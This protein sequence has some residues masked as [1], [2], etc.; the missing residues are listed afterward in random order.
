MRKKVARVVKMNVPAISS[1]DAGCNSKDFSGIF[2]NVN[3]H[4]EGPSFSGSW[5]LFWVAPVAILLSEVPIGL[6]APSASYLQRWALCSNRLANV[7]VSV[8]RV[9]VVERSSRDRLPLPLLSCVSWM[10]VKENQDRKKN[11]FLITGSSG[12]ETF[13]GRTNGIGKTM[14]S[15]Y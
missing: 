10:F 7:K 8:K 6:R 12:Y 5:L 2:K 11:N 3:V 1:S 15:G 9:E 13:F 14:I 4:T